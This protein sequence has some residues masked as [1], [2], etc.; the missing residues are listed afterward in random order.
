L[1]GKSE[2]SETEGRKLRSIG[3]KSRVRT[4]AASRESQAKLVKKL[5]AL[6]KTLDTRTRELGE[7]RNHLAEALEQ[8]TATSDV[9]QVISSSSGAL[10]PVFQALLA[11]AI[12]VI[13]AKF[14]TMYLREGDAFRIVAIYGASPAYVEALMRER[15]VRPD[16]ETAISRSARTKLAVQ[17]PDLKASEAYRRRVPRAVAAVEIGG[18]RTLLSVPMLRDDE[19]VGTIA[20]YRAE[21]RPFTDKQIELVKNFANRPSSQ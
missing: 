12:R 16:P 2:K 6:E 13:G 17:V 8:Q 18:V 11:N 3:T 7:A 21:V 15:L 4:A 5:K 1:A 19:L 9:L 14:G 20:I 10:E